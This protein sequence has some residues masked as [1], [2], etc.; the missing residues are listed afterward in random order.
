MKLAGTVAATHRYSKVQTFLPAGDVLTICD[1][2]GPIPLRLA[3]GVMGT[4]QHADNGQ[5]L[6]PKLPHPQVT[7]SHG[8][9]EQLSRAQATPGPSR[10]MSYSTRHNYRR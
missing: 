9:S 8:T 5:L 2:A 10:D 1:D 4:R 3:W 7:T 6:K